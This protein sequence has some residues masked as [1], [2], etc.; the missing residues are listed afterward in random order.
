MAFIV[1]YLDD[2]NAGLQMK[3]YNWLLSANLITAYGMLLSFPFQGYG[4]ISIT[5]STLSIFVGY[6]FSIAVRKDLNHLPF[7]SISH[8]KF[9]FKKSCIRRSG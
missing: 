1:K 9:R 5:F 6:A 8:H 7:K 2:R 3:K 4:P